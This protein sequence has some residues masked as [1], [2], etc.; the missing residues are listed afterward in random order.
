[1]PVCFSLISA[2]HYCAIPFLTFAE[3]LCN[4]TQDCARFYCALPQ[5]F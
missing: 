5:N 3:N 2:S 1:V 4:I